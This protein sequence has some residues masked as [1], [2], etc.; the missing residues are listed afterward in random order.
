MTCAS[1]STRPSWA[2]LASSALSRLFMV[3]RSWRSHTQR[4][5]AG[6]TVSPRFLSSLAT[7]GWLLNR[8][9]HDGVFD[10]L[11]H[12]VLQHRLFTADLLQRQLTTVVVEF[13]EPV[14]AVAAVAHDLAGLADVAEL[15]GKF[16]Q[17]NLRTDD[18]LFGR[19]DGVLQSPRRGASPPRPLR[20]PPRLAIRRGEPGHRCQIKF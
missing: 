8:E 9:R 6:E 20:A 10:L 12:A 4:T 14:K 17:P 3:S 11:R 19:H 15:L 18:L 2:L 7:K 1:V 16:K 13:L 5:P